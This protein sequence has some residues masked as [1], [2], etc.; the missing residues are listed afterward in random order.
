MNDCNDPFDMCVIPPLKFNSLLSYH[1]RQ[2]EVPDEDVDGRVRLVKNFR[3]IV[4]IYGK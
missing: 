2:V 1:A 3:G 4:R